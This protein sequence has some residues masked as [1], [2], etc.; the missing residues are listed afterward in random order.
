MF[1]GRVF[2]VAWTLFYVESIRVTRR[3]DLSGCHPMLDFQHVVQF[4]KLDGVHQDTFLQDLGCEVRANPVPATGEYTCE[5]N[6]FACASNIPNGTN[7]MCCKVKYLTRGGPKITTMFGESL[8]LFQSGV[9]TLFQI[10]KATEVPPSLLVEINVQPYAPYWYTMGCEEGRISEVVF[11]GTAVGESILSIRS[12][13]LSSSEPFAFRLGEGSWQEV[14]WKNYVVDNETTLLSSVGVTVTSMI[15]SKDPKH[16][17]PDASATVTVGG[18]SIG[19]QQQ[20]L[21]DGDESK[22]MLD[23]SVQ[24]TYSKSAGVGGLL[25]PDGATLLHSVEAVPCMTV[26][27]SV[28]R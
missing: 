3:G 11:S 15:S 25:G 6:F 10:P 12:G 7:Y 1:H 8:H 28:R 2:I 26:D 5:E 18:L 21:G 24:G 16:W 13:A 17:G 22:S 4:W 27:S 9:S 19:V 20:T 14:S 23:V